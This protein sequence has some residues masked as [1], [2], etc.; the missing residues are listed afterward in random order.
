MKSGNA[1]ACKIARFFLNTHFRT[2]SAVNAQTCLNCY[3]YIIIAL[4]C[5][6][7]NKRIINLQFVDK[8]WKLSEY[9]TNLLL[10]ALWHF[11]ML[12]VIFYKTPVCFLYYIDKGFSHYKM[13]IMWITPCITFFLLFFDILSVDNFMHLSTIFCE[14]LCFWYFFVHDSSFAY[15]I[16]LF[17]Y[18]NI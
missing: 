10:N 7:V 13:W 6:I 11:L 17:I 8:A 3:T 14:F 1:Y 5:F 16:N 9:F 4:Q 18:V 12:I 2:V 15:I